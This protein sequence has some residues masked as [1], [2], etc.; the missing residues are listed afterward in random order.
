MLSLTKSSLLL[1]SANIHKGHLSK[2]C[3]DPHTQ[4]S[5]FPSVELLSAA[6][7]RWALSDV[8]TETLSLS[9]TE[10]LSLSLLLLLLL[11]PPL[12]SLAG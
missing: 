7:G 10:A 11:L 4:H 5:N 1:L 3:L 9:L 12:M 2:S 6:I 8:V